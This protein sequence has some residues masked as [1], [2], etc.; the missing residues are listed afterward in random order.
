MLIIFINCY[1]WINWFKISSY[2]SDIHRIQLWNG[3]RWL[4]MSCID[5]TVLYTV[6]IY[7]N[8]LERSANK[9]LLNV[10][11]HVTTS[12]KL[13]KKCTT[14]MSLSAFPRTN[15]GESLTADI[16]CFSCYLCKCKVLC[17]TL[18]VLSNAQR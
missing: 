16:E 9:W 18:Q 13:K 12:I 10:S 8:S 17:T 6:V 15:F 3:F 11:P 7:I 1:D 2:K 4:C 14:I 5:L